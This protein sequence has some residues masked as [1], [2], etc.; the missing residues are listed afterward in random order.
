[1]ASRGGARPGSGRK[2]KAEEI[3][4]IKNMDSIADPDLVWQK[5]YENVKQG[6][7]QSIKTWLAYRFGMPKQTVDSNQNVTLNN[8]NLKDVVNFKE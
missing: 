7:V 2:P 8:F 4:L 3:S 5:L 1:M 6:D